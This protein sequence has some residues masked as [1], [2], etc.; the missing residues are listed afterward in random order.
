MIATPPQPGTWVDSPG[1]ISPRKVNDSANSPKRFTLRAYKTRMSYQIFDEEG[2]VGTL[3]APDKLIG[4]SVLQVNDNDNTL[5]ENLIDVSASGGL[6]SR[7]SSVDQRTDEEVG[8]IHDAIS[9]NFLFQY[10]TDSQRNALVAKMKAVAVKAGDIL[11][12]EGSDCSSE[13]NHFYVVESGIFSVTQDGVEVHVYEG[14]KESGKHPSFESFPYSTTNQGLQLSLQS[15]MASFLLC[16][17]ESSS[18]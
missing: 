1:E 12:K 15:Q 14:D 5:Q 3:S 6:R 13:N 2:D 17:D 16:L 4:G 10:L 9:N 8:T 18:K 7:T 11:I